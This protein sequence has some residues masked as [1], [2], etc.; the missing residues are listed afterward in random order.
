MDRKY[1]TNLILAVAMA[2]AA[3]TT[4]NA[5]EY[6]STPVSVSNE[7]VRVNGKICYSHI[8]REKQT[9]FSIAKAYDVSVD[10]IYAFNPSLKETGLKKNSIILIPSK[11]ALAKNTS[12]PEKTPEKATESKTRPA[13]TEVTKEEA[14]P[15]RK[16]V[17]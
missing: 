9:L 15:D 1:I 5:Q 7:K 13:N 10:D 2:C 14:R 8:V 6:T 17:V 3:A 12:E 11:E 4:G 16:S